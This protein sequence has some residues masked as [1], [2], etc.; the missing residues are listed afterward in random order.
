[1]KLR[2]HGFLIIMYKIEK[3]SIIKANDYF[4]IEGKINEKDYNIHSII[5][6]FE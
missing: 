2:E 1:M 6:P 4:V 3:Y 5:K